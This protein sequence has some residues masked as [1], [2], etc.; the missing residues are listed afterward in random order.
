MHRV[1]AKIERRGIDART[2]R[3]PGY[4]ISQTIRMRIEEIFGWAKTVGNFARTRLRGIAK[5]QHAAYLVG[6]AYNLMRIAKLVPLP[7]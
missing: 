2:T 6:A 3:H 7:P 4:R 1:A 5:T